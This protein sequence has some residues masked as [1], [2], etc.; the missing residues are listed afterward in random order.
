MPVCAENNASCSLHNSYVSL[1]YQIHKSYDK[2]KKISDAGIAA[3]NGNKERSHL[4][5]IRTRQTI[6]GNSQSRRNNYISGEG[7]KNKVHRSFNQCLF[8]GKDCRDGADVQSQVGTVQTPQEC[9]TSHQEAPQTYHDGFIF[10]SQSRMKNYQDIL[11]RELRMNNIRVR[12]WSTTSC[13]RAGF[14]KTIKVPRPTDEDRL[15]VCFHEIGHIVLGHCGWNKN[16]PRFIQEFDADMYGFQK[17]DEYGIAPTPDMYV[18]TKWHVL[19]RLAM[20]HN[21]GLNHNKIP[22]RINKWMDE[23]GVSIKSW[24]GNK[25]YVYCKTK[26]DTDVTIK[27]TIDIPKERLNELL[28]PHGMELVRSDIDDSTF[29]NWIIK[30]KDEDWDRRTFSR[31]FYNLSE[32]VSYMQRKE[33]LNLN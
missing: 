26:K 25:V 19:S 32:V 11:D 33:M 28:A 9:R 16:S 6:N 21:R 4:S 7:N 8:I 22:D 10:N 30:K 24:I 1:Q 20:A 17:L 2:I 3:F 13:G 5:V 29:G 14:D 23:Q 18:R 12:A 27:M 15:H 31:E